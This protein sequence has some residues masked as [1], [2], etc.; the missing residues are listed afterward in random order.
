ML[1]M[2]SPAES[3]NS[4]DI[5]LLQHTDRGVRTP[6]EQTYETLQA[7]F[8]YFNRG[9]FNGALPDCLITLQRQAKTFGY[10]SPRKFAA[11]DGDTLVD[12]IA[13][14]P[15]HFRVCTP[16]DTASTIAHEMTHLWQE[17]FGKPS[18]SGYHNQEW[19][20]AMRRIGLQPFSTNDPDKETGYSVNHRIVDGG[21]FDLSYQ[22]FE[23]TGQT[24]RWGDAFQPND[25]KRKPKRLTFVCPGCDQKVQGVAKIRVRCDPCDLLMVVRHKGETIEVPVDD[26]DAAS[27][28]TSAEEL[29]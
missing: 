4:G 14:N 21:P 12:E 1:Q 10:F 22:A 3:V 23:A 16:K 5:A 18:R 13:L 17:H 28:L 19:A 26:I 29:R 8:A 20:T 25:E 2:G 27:V 7:A 6:T 24:L 15:S 9:L 11:I